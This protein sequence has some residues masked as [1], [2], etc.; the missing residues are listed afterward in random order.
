MIIISLLTNK[1]ELYRL[2]RTTY[3]TRKSTDTRPDEDLFL[4]YKETV[5]KS[6]EN[7]AVTIEEDFKTSSETNKKEQFE[8]H[9]EN[10]HSNEKS[11]LK[12][13]YYLFLDLFCGFVSDLDRSIETQ[14][15]NETKRRFESFYSLNQTKF[16][17]CILNINLVLILSF[18]IVLFVFFSIPPQYHIF[19][20]INLNHTLT[21]N[22][23][24]I[25]LKS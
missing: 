3:W 9:N 18:A 19:K 23:H 5:A 12:R 1:V 21:F 6:Y 25:N 2:I 14:R 4:D 17:F 11:K 24:T 8:I 10:L 16:E 15:A 13:A 7:K 20:H 22:N